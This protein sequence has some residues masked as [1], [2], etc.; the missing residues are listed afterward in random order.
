MGVS[1]Y[2]KHKI[3]EAFY[4]LSAKV[5]FE[6]ITVEKIVDHSGVSK[7]TF[8]RHFRDKYDVLNYNSQAIAER[9]IG[10]KPCAN[11]REF[12]LRMFEEIE[13]EREYYRKAFKTSGQ[14]AHS[15]FLFEYSYGIVK[16]CYLKYKNVDQ[17]SSKEHYLIAHYCYGCVNLI[18]DWLK[19]STRLSAKEMAELCYEVMPECLRGTWNV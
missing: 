4:E 3:W 13:S 7:A 17:I 1:S 9:I 12:L 14:N 19:N 16:G 15:R 2:T 18:E 5:P 10:F 6:K 8:Y 11:W